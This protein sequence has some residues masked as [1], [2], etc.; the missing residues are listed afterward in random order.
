MIGVESFRG[1]GDPMHDEIREEVW[2]K[3]RR[4]A[5]AEILLPEAVIHNGPE[6]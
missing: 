5:I 3:G 6:E 4:E 1:A 2:S